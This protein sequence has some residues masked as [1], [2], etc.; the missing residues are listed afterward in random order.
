MNDK[1]REGRRG[2]ESKRGVKR[3]QR[4]ERD[5]LRMARICPMHAFK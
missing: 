4:H 1:G 5:F 2:E 3:R